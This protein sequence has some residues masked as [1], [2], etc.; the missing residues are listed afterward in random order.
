MDYKQTNIS[1]FMNKRKAKEKEVSKKIDVLCKDYPQIKNLI[2]KINSFGLYACINDISNKEFETKNKELNLKLKEEIK[3]LGFEEDYLDIKYDCNKCK[4]SGYIGKEMCQCLKEYLNKGKK[5]NGL[6][7]REG[8]FNG[9]REDLFSDDKTKFKISP[10]E[11]IIKNKEHTLNFI[12]EF[13]NENS[14]LGLL[15]SGTTG[16]GKTFLASAAGKVILKKGYSVIYLTAKEFEDIIKSFNDPNLEKRKKEILDVDLLILDDLGIET[17]SEYVN[18]EI[19][20]L[21]DYKMTYNKKMI[22]TTNLN[23]NE[24]RDKYKSR[25]YSRIVSNFKYLKFF[26]PDIRITSRMKK[27]Q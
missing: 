16:G 23:L 19:L 26:G 2:D 7:L 27:N 4:D 21:I 15:M 1:D 22:I 13:E 17:Q 5:K 24:I 20:K 9:F 11:N 25:I 10:K 8:S 3:K 14:I 6:L 18:N 12:N